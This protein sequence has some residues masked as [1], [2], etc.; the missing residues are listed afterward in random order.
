M[1]TSE[2]SIVELSSGGALAVAQPAD[3]DATEREGDKEEHSAPVCDDEPD[4]KPGG[5]GELVGSSSHF[6]RL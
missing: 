6:C 3:T 2:I 1:R 4:P 5:L